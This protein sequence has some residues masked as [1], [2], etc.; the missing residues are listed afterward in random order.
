[1]SLFDNV[2]SAASAL[3]GHVEQSGT[4]ALLLNTL[5]QWVQQEGGVSG[6][7][8]KFKSQGLGHLVES[9][10]SSG[11]NLPISAEQIQQVL[12][13]HVLE[14]FSSVTG[15]D[16]SAISHQL[17]AVL[18]EIISKLAPHHE[19]SEA[20]QGGFDATAALSMVQGLLG[21]KA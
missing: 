17:S 12:G 4:Q 8:E 9:W 21:A 10:I 7:L 11:Q 5:I 15:Q 16:T 3:S 6:V 1:M 20:S 14:K 13:T 2:L 19:A 18:P